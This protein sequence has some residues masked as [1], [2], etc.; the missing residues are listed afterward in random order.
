[1]WRTTEEGEQELD[2]GGRGKIRALFRDNNVYEL[3]NVIDN[4][5]PSCI[6]G[7]NNEEQRVG[8]GMENEEEPRCEN[9]SANCGQTS[10][11]AGCC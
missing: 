5:Q 4:L 6:C 11:Q 9:C 2:R 8:F 7:V 3:R 1:M 10:C